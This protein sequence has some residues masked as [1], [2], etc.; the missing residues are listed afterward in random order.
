[1]INLKKNKLRYFINKSEEGFSLVEALVAV[2]IFSLA[3]SLVL[4][5]LLFFV[6]MNRYSQARNFVVENLSFAMESMTREIRFGHTYHCG[7]KSGMPSLDDS[8]NIQSGD[9]CK[10][11]AFTLV[12]EEEEE[13]Y[14]EDGRRII[15]YLGEGD[16]EGR[17]MKVID[18][19]LPGKPVTAESINI[20]DLNFFVRNNTPYVVIVLKGEAE[21]EGEKSGFN[22]QTSVS[23]RDL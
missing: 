14:G 10:Y 20:Q 11:I 23:G 6:S 2:S 12:R 16:N 8:S 9:E 18:G 7:Q 22:L 1:M 13:E 15:Y 19:D 21:V 4:G 3:V 5:V 17:L